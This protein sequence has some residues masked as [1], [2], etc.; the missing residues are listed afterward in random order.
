MRGGM[1]LLLSPI[2][3]SGARFVRKLADILSTPL[4][5]IGALS[6]TAFSAGK[7]L[8]KRELGLEAYLQAMLVSIYQY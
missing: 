6:W 5:I 2:I 1:I 8:G 7:Q 4:G 3:L